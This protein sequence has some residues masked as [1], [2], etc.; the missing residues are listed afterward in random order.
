MIKSVL[1]KCMPTLVLAN[2][3]SIIK[4]IFRKCA[5]IIQLIMILKE[6]QSFQIIATSR[7]AQHLG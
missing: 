3:I 5:L 4:S 2:A 7:I 1:T 6:F